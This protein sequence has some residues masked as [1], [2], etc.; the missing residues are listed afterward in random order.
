MAEGLWIE[1][2]SLATQAPEKVDAQAPPDDLTGLLD[3]GKASAELHAVLQNDFALLL[4]RVP[5]DL[6]EDSDVI[7]AARTADLAPVLARAAAALQARLEEG[8]AQ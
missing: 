6:G 2:V 8:G 3:E 7:A 4:S 1:K 5:P